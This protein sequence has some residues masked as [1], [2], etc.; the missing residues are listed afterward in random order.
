ML[1]FPYTNTQNGRPRNW[2]HRPREF[3]L[4][5][6]D[7]VRLA[8]ADGWRPESRGKTYNFA[9]PDDPNDPSRPESYR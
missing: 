2:P 3:V 6:E 5:L 4:Q 7:A 8:M 1:E 9:L